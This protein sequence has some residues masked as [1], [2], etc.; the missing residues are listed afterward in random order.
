MS[1]KCDHLVNTYIYTTDTISKSY[2]WELRLA[3]LI[4]SKLE[5]YLLPHANSGQTSCT[6]RPEEKVY[7][8]TIQNDIFLH[9]RSKLLS[10]S[11]LQ[12]KGMV[13]LKGKAF[14]E[15]ITSSELFLLINLTQTIISFGTNSIFCH[16]LRILLT[17]WNSKVYM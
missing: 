16:Q 2:I 6:I 8:L 13:R 17:N 14:V 4:K 7:W 9:L 1:T 15:L 3:T 10:D 12:P 11:I 5:G